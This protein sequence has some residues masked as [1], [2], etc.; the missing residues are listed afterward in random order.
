[1]SVNAFEVWAKL[2]LDISEYKKGLNSA[3]SGLSGFGS[4]LKSTF[5]T[6]AKAA[7][8]AFAASTAAVT[9]FSKSAIDAG[10]SFD[11][12]MSQ[13]AATMGVT[14][15]EIQELRDY[16]QEMG[17]TTAFSATQA[18]EALNYMALAGYDATTSMEMLPNVLN[19][20]A[21]GGM[22]LG[23][24]SDMIT[25]SQSALG[26][27]LD[28][29]SELVN[30]M[31]QAASKSNTSVEQ[32]G[33][34]ILTVGGTAKNLKGGTTE[35]ATVLGILADNGIKGAEGGTALRNI[36]NSLTAPTDKAA[37]L[38]AELGVSV[39]D[40][41][42]NIRSL[43]DVFLDLNNAM[44]TMT[45]R[46]RM[47]VISTL[48]NARDMKSAN[49]LLAN[50]GDRYEELSGYIN[51]AAGAAEAMAGTQLDNLAGDITL[52]KSALEGAQIALSDRLTPTLRN[53]TKFGSESISKLTTA[54]KKDGV[55][56]ALAAFDDIIDGGFE[57][58]DTVVPQM[59]ETGALLMGKLISGF[60]RKLPDIV[61]SGVQIVGTLATTL[62][63]EMPNLIETTWTALSALG[64]ALYDNA[65]VPA[66]DFVTTKLPDL[67]ND[68]I[69]MLDLA[70]VGSTLS[71]KFKTILEGTNS[72]INAIDWEN[73]GSTIAD[74]MNGIDW[75]GILKSIFETIGTIIKNT[76]SLLKG[77]IE[78]LDAE[79]EAV[80]V[81]ATFGKFLISSMSEQLL[82]NST[83]QT[84]QSIG[85]AWATKLAIGFSSFMVGWSIGTLI[86]DKMGDEIDATVEDYIDQWLIGAEDLKEGW[87]SM[88]HN[89]K[90][91]WSD[92]LAML[93]EGWDNAKQSANDFVGMVETGWSTTTGFFS[94]ME[95]CLEETGEKANDKIEE[96]KD[97]WRTGGLEIWNKIDDI[98]AKWL[99][100]QD[101]WGI[102]VSTIETGLVNIG[103][104]F[105]NLWD[106]ITS[107]ISDA[108]TW[109]SDLISGFAQGIRDSFFEAEGALEDFGEMIYDYIHFSQPDKGPLSG[110]HGFMSYAPDMIKSFAEGIAQNAGSVE[111]EINDLMG[112]IQAKFENPMS[113]SINTLPSV[114]AGGST[115]NVVNSDGVITLVMVSEAG[116]RLAESISQPADIINGAKINLAKRG[117]AI[118]G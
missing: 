85:S 24:A 77:V 50:V 84:F 83:F 67:I 74:F 23:R 73:V 75:S 112:G 11:S 47:N 13:V 79:A 96:F 81:G 64:T 88:V 48:F 101:T 102:G 110:P 9:A 114:Q 42:D 7:V 49:A 89:V 116:E 113:M 115:G 38:M 78:N 104:W 56:G 29:T 16:A 15:D 117:L 68:G 41:E 39:F 26:L 98:Q 109:G 12:A 43:N 46:E 57:L 35:L 69:S 80:L 53:F 63:N 4:A 31:A 32:L 91:G 76:P 17:A 1:M 55:D 22:D 94:D 6:I 45:Q 40:T 36:L 14:V 21:A 90:E 72:F 5:S 86:Y 108:W 66:W 118:N 8:P 58:L 30:K 20:A 25:D 105:S 71:D 34:A 54:F 106:N 10:M 99:D 52:F 33:D 28:E 107:G 44:S 51:D 59:L 97:N 93:G 87:L 82:A 92:D 62:K 100:W 18:A 3:K 19:L 2:G 65:I 103:T 111:D 61:N 95:E 60:V 70:K 27:S 37:D